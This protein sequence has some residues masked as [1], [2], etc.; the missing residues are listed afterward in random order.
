VV[1]VIFASCSEDLVEHLIDEVEK[2]FPA[3]PTVVMSEFEPKRD[4]E[5]IPYRISWTFEENER[6]LLSKLNGRKVAEA[7]IALQPN[8]PYWPMRKLGY[9]IKQYGLL[10]F[11]ENLNHFSL[12]PSSVPAMIRH[13]FWRTGNLIRWQMRPGGKTY[14]WLWRFL[15]PIDGFRR[16]VLYRMAQWAGSKFRTFPSP[17]PLP[18]LDKPLPTGVTVVIPSR[19]GKELLMECLPLVMAEKPSEVIVVDNG[20]DDGT[21]AWI[22]KAHPD[23]IVIENRAALSFARAVNRGIAQARFSHVCLLNNDMLI[24]PGFFSELQRAFDCVPDLFSSTAQIFFPPGQRREETG[25]AVMLPREHPSDFLPHCVE[26]L[27]GEDHSYVLYGSGGCSLYDTRKL[28]QLGAIGEVFEPAYVEDLDI[29][30]RGWRQGWP[31]VYVAGAKVLHKHRAT[32]SRYLTENELKFA[33]E[34][35]FLRFLVRS[36]TDRLLFARMWFEA[37]YRINWYACENP[38]YMPIL[39]AAQKAPDWVEAQPVAVIPEEE[40]FD[41]NNG[42][43]AVFPGRARSSGK[44]MVLVASCYLPFPLSHGGAVRMYNLMRRAAL[45]FDQVLIAFSTH[46]EPVP[47]ELLE[48]CTEV[49]VVQATG[50]HDQA[51]TARPQVVEEFDRPEFRAALRQTIRKHKPAI[52]QL[53]FTQLAAY[54]EDCAPAKTILVEHDITLDLYGQLRKTSPQDWELEREHAKWIQFEEQAWREVDCVITMSSKDKQMVKDAKRVEPVINGVDLDRFR[55]STDEPATARL[56]FIGSF[57]HLPNVLALDWFLKE[58]WPH[59]QEAKPILH[60][61][62][63]RNPDVYLERYKDHARPDL[64]QP[65]IELEG[66]VSDVRPA[67]RRASIVVAPLL[68]SAGTNIKIMEAMAMGKAIVSTPGG[69]N[70]LELEEGKVVLVAKT[71]EEMA[72]Q[73]LNLIKHPMKRI[74]LERAAHNAAERDFDWDAVARRQAEIYRSM[75][76]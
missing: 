33:L 30:F 4:V 6:L 12:R 23:C 5:W 24:E 22:R 35:N 67:Y 61:I 76:G 54:A 66:F 18:A 10:V 32:T 38:P 36:V 44:P 9:R 43:V 68:A 73:I 26:P 13:F 40:I 17:L 46:L 75:I 19:N 74:N 58:V 41:L 42:R 2:V 49:V 48:I 65:G 56:L 7:A 51:L 11:N 39:K 16:P 69:I 27:P 52:A 14:T 3:L 37:I 60:I 59:I 71:G 15:H 34:V 64:K 55:P 47:R 25:K 70:G 28:R 31:S 57:A 8:M 21:A 50:S 20:S 62:A 63:G 29:G 72:A 45:D 1:K 53:E